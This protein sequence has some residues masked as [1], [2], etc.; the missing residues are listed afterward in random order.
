MMHTRCSQTVRWVVVAL[1]IILMSLPGTAF[2]NDGS[3]EALYRK[4]T[5]IATG[6]G[7]ISLLDQL[8]SESR[9][10]DWDRAD[11]TTFVGNLRIIKSTREDAVENKDRIYLLRK[12]SGE[13]YILSLP[14]DPSL[15]AEGADSLYA[16]LDGIS[17]N[18]MTFSVKTMNAMIA[19]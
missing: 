18:K 19:G 15:R 11:E 13:L 1:F 16:G 8:N 5:G 12:L 17:G 6:T 7:N 4:L 9:E 3:H 2:A 10:L 14:A